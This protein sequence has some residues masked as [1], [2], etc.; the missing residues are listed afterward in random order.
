VVRDFNVVQTPDGSAVLRGQVTPQMTT[1]GG[2]LAT[3]SLTTIIQEAAR[4]CLRRARHVDMLIENMTLYV[5]RPVPVDTT[6]DARARVLNDGRRYAKVEVEI[7]DK[8]DV[9]AKA[10]VTAQWIER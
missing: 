5:L 7:A 2:T 4:V 6:I 8:N 3:G 9:F 10:L 1:S